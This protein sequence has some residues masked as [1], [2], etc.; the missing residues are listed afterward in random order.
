MSASRHQVL[1]I[2]SGPAGYTAALYA[3]RANLAPLMISGLQPGGQLTITTD[4]E[5]F[6]GFPEGILGPDLMDKFKAQAERFGTVIRHETVESVELGARPFVVQTDEARYEADA[7]IIATGASARWLGIPAEQALM[8]HGVSACATCDG[9]FFRGKDV[10]IVGGGDT[11]LEEANFLTRFCS[12]VT[13]VHR[14]DE[15]RASKIMRD[16]AM[17]N[18]KIDFLWNAQVV[19]ILGSKENGVHAA[20]IRDTVSGEEREV[21]TQGVFVAIGHKPNTELFQGKLTLDQAGYLVVTPG[22]AST[23]IEGVFACGDVADHKYRQAITAAGTGC[24]AAM[25]AE[26]YLEALHATPAGAVS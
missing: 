6:P 24:M 5:N 16:R 12:R 17:G 11:A 4:V 14:R 10:L 13:V 3:A 2:G 7:L 25:E 18:P 9:F 8:G 21:A 23:E 26:R 1:I 22:S 19:D 20:R 15:L